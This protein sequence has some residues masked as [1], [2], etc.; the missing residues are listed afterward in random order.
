MPT[1]YNAN[2]KRLNAGRWWLYRDSAGTR[3][4]RLPTREIGILL[5]E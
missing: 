1:E 2:L 3:T 4:N 5:T